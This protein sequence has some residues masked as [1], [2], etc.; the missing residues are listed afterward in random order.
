MKKED[1]SVIIGQLSEQLQKY[2]NFYLTDIEA[3][4][5]SKTGALRRACFKKEIKLVVV[6]NTLLKKALENAGNDFSPLYDTLKGNTAVMFST[7]INAP[8]R[9]I[10][11]FTR[12][13]KGDAKPRLKAAYVQ[14]MFYVGAENLDALVNL[15]SREEMIADVVSLLQSP[16]RNLISALSSGGQAIHG[17]LK[18]LEER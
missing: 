6:K 4:N 13:I 17:I 14:E 5:A 1:K 15:K 3:L 16:V 11:D 2:G 9:L 10:K 12:G 18:T 7:V 8:A